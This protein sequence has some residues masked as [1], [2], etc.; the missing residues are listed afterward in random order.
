MR[1]VAWDLAICTTAVAASPP[2]IIVLMSDDLGWNNV[3]FHNAR[4]HTPHLDALRAAGVELSR[5]YGASAR[6]RAPLTTP[7]TWLTHAPKAY[8]FCSPTRSSFLSGRLPVHVNELNSITEAPG[9][10]IPAAMATL[11]KIL[12]PAG[13]VSHH[14]GKWHAG[15]ASRSQSTPVAR[16]FAS[17][18]AYFH[19]EEDHYRQTAPGSIDCSQPPGRGPGGGGTKLFADLWLDEGPANKL[20]GTDY[21]MF[22]YRDRALSII[23]AH[24]AAAA[25]LF[26]FLAFANNHAPLQCPARYTATYPDPGP[27]ASAGQRQWRTYQGMITA[28]DEV[29]GNVTDALRHKGMYDG[30]LVVWFSDNG[31]PTYEGG[32]ASNWPLRGGKISN[33]EGGVRVAALVSG[34]AIPPGRRN[35]TYAG[36]SA[37]A[38][39]MATFADAAG[40][41]PPADAAAAAAG[42]PPIDSVSHWRALTSLAPGAGAAAMSPRA[43]VPLLLSSN[44]TD[45]K[46]ASGTKS[47]ALLLDN[48]KL[49]VGQ[50][51]CADWSGRVFPNATD[52]N[53]CLTS[54]VLQ[55]GGA[56]KGCLFDV[57]G[58][59]GEH[60]DVSAA[61]PDVLTEMQ[62]MLRD[63][64]KRVFRPDRGCDGESCAEAVC[65]AADAAGGF[66][67]P[68]LP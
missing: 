61:H 22:L 59:P 5:H 39:W 57:V 33:F 7:P 40:L 11:P 18:L 17:S 1:V 20:N 51:L 38:D 52:T 32:G 19:G 67:A 4:V 53:A 30:A 60:H 24:D 37:V 25:P 45:A 42:L 64:E 56:S 63:E 31:G 47:A 16:G 66:W 21:S 41:P 8:K 50:S 55:C 46:I 10:G 26:L 12:A 23:A 58:D 34:G 48:W 68:F 14:I 29:V 9:A 54:S 36:V 62:G 15:F 43:G 3:G 49:L 28:V 27:G 13:Y 2:H 35:G 6:A 65:K 44:Y